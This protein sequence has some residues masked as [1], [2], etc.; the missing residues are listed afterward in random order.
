MTE[1][2][3][4]AA[5][6]VVPASE[7]VTTAIG[8]P[9]RLAVGGILGPITFIAA[10]TIGGI[11]AS[12]YSPV[13]DA[14][15]HLAEIGAS[16]RALMTTGFVAFGVGVLIYAI[17]LR[18]ALPGWSWLTAGASG[19]ATLGVAA[20]PLG[21]SSAGDAL[22]GTFA[23]TG[24]VMLALTPLLAAGPF[25]RSG[26]ELAARASLVVG[27]ISALSLVATTTV[28]FDG[29]CQ[30][31]GLTIVDLWIVITAVAILRGR[32][33]ARRSGRERAKLARC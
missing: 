14:I 17:A 5:P 24:Y 6:V 10:W 18:A 13:D 2:G 20:A 7:R 32:L 1:G 30:R 8:A 23:G 27:S 29:L 9:R 26:Q 22:H 28:T 31:A 16:T 33:G 12:H 4:L 25:R 15:S 21:R 11:V 3:H 19:L